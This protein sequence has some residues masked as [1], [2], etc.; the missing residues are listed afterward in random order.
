MRD[1]GVV[2]GGWSHSVEVEECLE[3]LAS[4]REYEDEQEVA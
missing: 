3:R 2:H 1:C 4:R